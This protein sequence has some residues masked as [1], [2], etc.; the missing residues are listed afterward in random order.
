M[1]SM[2]STENEMV[3]EKAIHGIR[4]KLRAGQAKPIS[5]KCRRCGNKHPI[6]KCPAWG[7]KCGGVNHF[8]RMCLS[9]NTTSQVH[10][11]STQQSENVFP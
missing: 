9:R 3:S 10:E 4:S 8:A 1:Q 6:H 2:K 7:E 11:V 5:Q